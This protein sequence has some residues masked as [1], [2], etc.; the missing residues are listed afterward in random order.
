[1]KKLKLTKLMASTLLVTSVLVLNPIGASATGIPVAT[2]K[3]NQWIQVNGAWQYNDVTGNPVK[4]SWLYDKKAGKYYYLGADGSMYTSC[5]IPTNGGYYYLNSD[6]TMATNTTI[7]GYIVGA[8]G[9]WNG[10]TPST[11]INPVIINNGDNAQT[12]NSTVNTVKSIQTVYDLENYFNENYSSLQTP[13]GTLKFTFSVDENDSKLSDYDFWIQTKYGEIDNSKYDLYSFSPYDLED[14]IK[15]S[16]SDKENT[17]ELLKQM[18]ENIAK[19]AI[20]YFPNKKICGGFYDSWYKYA[21]LQVGL[22]SSQFLSW[23]NYYCENVNYNKD[24]NGN[25][26]FNTYDRSHVSD[27]QWDNTID[28]FD[29]SK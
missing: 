23:K 2:T 20:K 28:D 29:F 1:M 21:Y 9:A 5:W 27:F 18:Q 25:Y 7:N 10:T 26:D 15:I 19:D 13:I 22:E 8:D 24:E 14:S 16:G 12:S 3:S 17:K 6:G 4:N 11:A